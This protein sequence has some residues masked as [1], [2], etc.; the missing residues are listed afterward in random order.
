MEAILDELLNTALSSQISADPATGTEKV[1]ATHSKEIHRVPYY[2]LAAHAERQ[3]VE[4]Q[5]Q[6]SQAL[7]EQATAAAA[8]SKAAVAAL[9]QH[10]QTE[11]PCNINGVMCT[12]MA[13]TN[14]S[15]H[16]PSKTHDIVRS[17]FGPSS[18]ALS[19]TV[20][21]HEYGPVALSVHHTHCLEG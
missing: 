6:S 2:Q 12:M 11:V 18:N 16:A 10:H 21:L 4:Q 9:R 13:S 8:A 15:M 3:L 5:K 19:Y 1:I 14:V 17:M 7:H 20:S